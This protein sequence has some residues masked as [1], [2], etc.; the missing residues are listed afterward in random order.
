VRYTQ[1]VPDDPYMSSLW[2]MTN[3]GA[4]AAWDTQT[5]SAAVRVGV[6]DTGVAWTHPDLAAN[7][8]TNPGETPGNGVDDDGN[9][10]VDDVHGYDFGEGDGDPSDAEGHGTHVAGTI[11][12]VG[13]NG[14]GVA[15]VCWSVRIVCLKIAT[16]WGGLS[17]SAAISATYYASNV[18]CILTS[19]SWGGYG[20]SSAL[21]SAITAANSA[22][23]LFVAA[24]GNESNDNDSS[25]AYPASYPQSNIISVAATTSSGAKADFSNWGATRVD[26]GAPGVSI[27]STVP[28]GYAYMSGTSMATPMVSGACALVK[29]QFPSY[30]HLAVRSQVLSTVTTSGSL[31]GLVATGGRLNLA[32][33]IETG[34]APPPSSPGASI[35]V[36]TL[37]GTTATID[38]S[39][40]EHFTARTPVSG[41]TSASAAGIGEPSYTGFYTA[42]TN[43][44]TFTSGGST[45]DTGGRAVWAS[46][47]NGFTVPLTGGGTVHVFVSIYHTP[48]GSA[49]YALSAGGATATVTKSTTGVTL[50]RFDVTFTGTATFAL[51]CGAT[52]ESSTVTLGGVRVP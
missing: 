41:N 21:S 52:L 43:R 11:G 33:A 9:G 45:V 29:A 49:T 7:I 35:S 47:G 4:P 50:Y 38:V 30:S 13:D 37:G 20:Y 46:A 27:R 1:V 39:G 19:N 31:S 23:V 3:V 28:G 15:G 8:W 48:S 18:G 36:V 25:P 17:T 42:H 44:W 16:S 14:V 6:I 12:A 10:Y 51:S 26:I 34:A 32:A 2:G 40:Q 22:G 5:G 24:A